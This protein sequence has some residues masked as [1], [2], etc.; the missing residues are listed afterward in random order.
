MK[1]TTRYVLK[2]AAAALAFACFVS[3]TQAD[4]IDLGERTLTTPLT[5]LSAAQAYIEMDQGLPPGT[6]TYFNSF[7]SDVGWR[8]N[9]ALDSSYFGVTL[10]M[11]ETTAAVNWDL[12]TSGFQLSY[13]FLKDGREKNGTDYHYHLYGVTPDE[14]FQSMGDQTVEIDGIRLINY[15]A[16]FGVPG[17]PNV[18]EGGATL[19][20]LGIG[21]GTIEL[22]RRIRLWRAAEIV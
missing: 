19:I 17:S 6:L 22:M 20:L 5:G 15:V 9:G 4:L 13:V 1:S 3:Q 14:V 2:T 12:S 10:S 11:D 8:N 7:D 16:F 18:P 21:L